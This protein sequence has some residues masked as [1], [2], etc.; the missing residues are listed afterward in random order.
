MPTPMSSGRL[1]FSL[2]FE[3]DPALVGIHPR[4]SSMRISKVTPSAPVAR[5]MVRPIR[6][7]QKPLFRVL[8][9]L[10]W[11][12]R[13]T[14]LQ[15][16]LNDA[17]LVASLDLEV[18][19]FATYDVRIK[20]VSLVL[21]QG[22]VKELS[23][24]YDATVSHKPGD[25]L[26]YLY[27]ILPD[28]APDGTPTLGSKGHYLTLNVE[29]NVTVASDCR[30]D[31]A[32]EWKTPVDFTSEQAS[33]LAKISHHRLS[34]SATHTTSASN[35]DSLP[36]PGTQDAQE[37][38]PPNNDVNVTLTVSGPPS[39]R[40]GD[41]FTWDIF[42]VNR[43]DKL[44]RLAILVIVKR[45]KDLEIHRP[46]SSASSIGGARTDKREL[47]AAAVT[48]ENVVYAKQKSARIETA[49]LICLTTDIRVGTRHRLLYQLNSRWIYGKIPLLH[50]LVFLLQMAA[51]SMLT[52]KY[53]QYYAARPVLTTMI[54]NA[55]LG[56]IA[57]TVAQTL[58][59]VRERAV[60]KK[61]GP[62]KDDFLAIEIHD[63]D[64]RNPLNDNELIPDSK[65]LPPP[66]DFER[67]TRFMS[68]GF[69]MSP[70][71][72]RWFRFLS[73]TFP[74]SKTAT[75]LPALKRVAFDQFLFAPAGLA[76]F[77]TFMTVA[78]GGGKRAVQRKFQDVYVP[79]LKAN[80]MV[81]PAVQLI[82]FRVMPIQFQIPFVSTVGIAW[83]AY[84]SLTNSA[85]EA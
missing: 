64:K 15:A 82:N 74:V 73:A 81:W 5:E 84:L 29:A 1:T 70:I 42:I 83:T 14:K 26:T 41:I 33:S 16:A 59:A 27:K 58:T 8:P 4:L 57:D 72:H 18:A 13:Y 44:R 20:K 37:Q 80:Y 66:F 67:T 56:G 75:W 39:V 45:P 76:A 40:V 50:S 9:P 69:L 17:S 24:K 54:T 79:A 23:D 71:Q 63:L 43:S 38:T 49:E 51:V 31:I 53:N 19:Q 12:M 78:E 52:R 36:A 61:G 3:N 30:P 6:N 10:I 46:R 48:D 85:E 25:Q 60:R 77:F 7:G 68:Y 32:I 55:V 11:R 28:L 21:H 22:K 47:L 34:S 2:S 35:P 65:K 62:G